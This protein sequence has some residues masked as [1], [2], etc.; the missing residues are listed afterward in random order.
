[1]VLLDDR[2][3]MPQAA[4]RGGLFMEAVL[5]LIALC[6]AGFTI[7]RLPLGRIQSLTG[8]FDLFRCANGQF[9]MRFGDGRDPRSARDVK[10]DDEIDA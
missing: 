1:M 10:P 7:A 4:T 6:V 2:T 9:S 3:V 5:V 8:R